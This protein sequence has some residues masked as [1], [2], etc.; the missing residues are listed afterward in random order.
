MLQKFIL[1]LILSSIII[2]PALGGNEMKEIWELTKDGWYDIDL[3]ITSMNVADNGYVTVVAKGLF[4]GKLV[5]LKISFSPNLKPGL[6]NGEVDKSAF[7]KSGIIYSSIGSESDE[8]L[9]AIATLYSVE[10]SKPNFSNSVATTAFALEQ[11]L[12]NLEKNNVKFKVFFNDQG[13]EREY[14][15]LF[16]NIDIPKNRL[17][18]HEKDPEYRNNVVKALTEK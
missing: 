13:D 2:S 6:L 3:T 1:T 18:L 11:H 17:E 15:E 16:T 5:G 10:L 12:F 14:A 8:L 9:K 4:R 7:I